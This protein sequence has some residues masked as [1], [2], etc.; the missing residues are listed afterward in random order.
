MET[1]RRFENRVEIVKGLEPGERIVVSGNFLI[2][3]E[4][5]LQEAADMYLP[6]AGPEQPSGNAKTAKHPPSPPTVAPKPA[7]PGGHRG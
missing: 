7:D 1:G 3:S 2:N 4:S 6:P 5:R